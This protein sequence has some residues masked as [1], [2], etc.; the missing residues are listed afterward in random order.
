MAFPP[1]E[2]I[3]D[4]GI[5]L[6]LMVTIEPLIDMAQQAPFR[7]HSGWY[8]G[9]HRMTNHARLELLRLCEGVLGLCIVIHIYFNIY[10]VNKHLFTC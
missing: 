5:V 1:A 10:R 8:I 7:E 9:L 2:T 6:A 3:S 4:E